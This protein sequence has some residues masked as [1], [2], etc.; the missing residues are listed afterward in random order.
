MVRVP[1]KLPNAISTAAKK[2]VAAL[3]AS[4]SPI[5]AKLAAANDAAQAKA[6]LSA[7]TSGQP[8]H[9]RKRLHA[10]RAPPR[11]EGTRLMSKQEVLGIVGCSFPTLWGWMRAG[12]FPRSRVVGGKSKWL[13]SEVEA[14]MQAL[15]TR[16]LKGDPAETGS[17]RPIRQRH[18]GT[19]R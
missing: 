13:S 17:G 1:T 9:D 18:G 2:A 3:E 15:P 4:P 16:R 5:A 6:A 7:E 12:T 14:W 10:P 8:A 11:V 19:T